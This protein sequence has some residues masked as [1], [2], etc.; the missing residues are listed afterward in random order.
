MEYGNEPDDYIAAGSTIEAWGV[1]GLLK[2][3]VY[4]ARARLLA[5]TM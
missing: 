5:A 2:P 4:L 3:V 1:K